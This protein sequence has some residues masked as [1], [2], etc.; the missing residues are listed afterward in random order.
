MGKNYQLEY[1]ASKLEQ[2]IVA[3]R[4][5]HESIVEYKHYQYSKNKEKADMM[6]KKYQEE[7]NTLARVSLEKEIT[8]TKLADQINENKLI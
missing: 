3:Q 2:D 5:E 8:E 7:C 6:Q 4:L 1:K